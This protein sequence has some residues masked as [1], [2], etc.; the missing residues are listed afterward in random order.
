MLR[1]LFVHA[2]VGVALLCTA[3]GA[4]AAERV[5]PATWGPYARL[6]GSTQ[7][8]EQGYR[9]TWR[10]IEPGRKL[11][12]DWFE[13]WSGELSY[14]TTITPGAQPGQLVLESPKFGH[15]TWNGTI[16][17][18]GSV[19]YVGVGMLKVPYRVR[20]DA[21][22]RMAMSQV[23]LDGGQGTDT[24]T[25]QYDPAD[26][27]GV[28]PRPNARPADPKVWGVYARLLGAHLAGKAWTAITWSWMG[29]NAMLQDRGFLQPRLQISPD[30]AGGLTMTSGKPA[31]I[32]S[33]TIAPDGAVVWTSKR[34]DSFRV[35][36]AGNEAVI[37]NV[38]LENGVVLRTKSD[39][40]YRGHLPAAAP[41]ADSAG[42]SRLH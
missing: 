30:G 13:A 11:A 17:P 26:T 31:E 35:R 28:L 37:E 4:A 39:V 24:S 3:I 2:I 42:A 9:V 25:M 14:T 21:D 8:S 16:A 33:G 19:L 20:V 22:G 32:W 15:K 40:R 38:V 41:L 10:W 29:E 6:L 7:Q 18:D 34:G 1:R 5:D 12:E 23:K 27:L 36:I